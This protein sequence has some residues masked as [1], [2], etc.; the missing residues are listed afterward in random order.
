MEDCGGPYLFEGW[1]APY[2]EDGRRDP[3]REGWRLLNTASVCLRPGAPGAPYSDEGAPP[4]DGGRYLLSTGGSAKHT[5]AN[6]LRMRIFIVLRLSV[7]SFTENFYLQNTSLNGY[8]SQIQIWN[9]E[10]RRP[11]LPE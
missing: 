9:T 10:R 1:G 4:A 3:A 7:I 6:A 11:M 5:T 2:W 8:I